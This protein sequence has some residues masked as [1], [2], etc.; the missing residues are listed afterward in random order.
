M[1]SRHTFH[2]LIEM[3]RSE[4]AHIRARRAELRYMG[5]EPDF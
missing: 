5:Q 4:A 3:T 1:K 2:E